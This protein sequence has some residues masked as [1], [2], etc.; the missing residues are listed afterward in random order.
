MAYIT[1]M[2]NMLNT[3]RL[4][5]PKVHNH[6]YHAVRPAGQLLAHKLIL[7]RKQCKLQRVVE[8]TL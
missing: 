2:L 1:V 6:R 8:I 5:W 4:K 3:V 7:Q